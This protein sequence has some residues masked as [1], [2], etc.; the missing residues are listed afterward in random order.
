MFHVKHC[1]GFSKSA[2]YVIK[3]M[4][5]PEQ[6]ESRNCLQVRSSPFMVTILPATLIGERVKSPVNRDC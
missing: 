5:T 6:K 2:R 1:F 4:T 3:I